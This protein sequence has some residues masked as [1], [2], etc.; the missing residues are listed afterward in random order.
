MELT[1]VAAVGGNR[2]RWHEVPPHVRAA[3]ESR[4]GAPVVAADSKS[5]GFSPALASVLTLA[6]GRTVFVKAVSTARNEFTAG[7]IRRET[8]V[9]AGLPAHVPA[10]RLL[11]AFDDGEW[12]ALVIEAVDGDNPAQ[13]WHRGEL[14]RFLDATTVLAGSLT[15]AP[16]EARRF[17]ESVDEFTQWSQMDPD[18]LDREFGT[19]LDALIRLEQHWSDA[20]DGTALLHGDLRADN[21]LLT[22]DSF[23]VVDWPWA[24]IGAPWCD[25]LYALPSVAMHG[26][27]DPDELWRGHEL[28]RS[29]D[30]DA[31]NA[32]LAGAAGF[33]IARSLQP[34]VPL[35]PTIRDFQRAQG[36]VTFRWLAARLG[37]R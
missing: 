6:D 22:A 12:V 28:S 37:W 10:A 13:P 17:V 31:V 4:V 11:S 24:G 33:F 26:G 7:A 25:L 5:G 9:L 23:V 36:V 32:A 34:P 30:D 2:L 27:G 16:I 8:A 29:V 18:R 14:T 20:V 1:A 19:H 15:P 3:I 21:F 35:I